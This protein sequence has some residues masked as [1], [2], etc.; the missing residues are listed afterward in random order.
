MAATP[1][2][3][4]YDG[5]AIAYHVIGDGE[6]LVVLPGGPGRPSGYLGDLGGL[7]RS[8]RLILMDLRGTGDSATPEDAG[9]YRVDRQARDVEALVN[10][11]GLGPV[12]VLGHS[13]GA[14]MAVLFA[15]AHPERVRRL[16]LVTPSG[17]VLGV[18]MI[19]FEEAVAARSAEPWYADAIA[20]DAALE[21]LPD[22]AD[23][24]ERVQL[25]ARVTPFFYGRWDAAAAAHSVAFPH[26]DAA[27][28]G[29]YR[30]FTSDAPAVRAQLAAM[31]A[32]TLVVAGEV[33]GMPTPAVAEVI[34]KVFRNGRA[35]TVAGG[36]YPW[37]D[38]SAVF[39]TTIREFLE[40]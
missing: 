27:A 29:Y 10:H 30:D 33:D 12:D 40:A 14:S 11:L 32:P 8:R 22:D 31:A 25:L 34:A 2:F 3:S 38:D 19:G 4:S 21:D 6:P 39:V 35:A 26:V 20:A 24:A 28:I 1:T 15:A 36:H 23:L 13:A 5:V 9:S 17:R 7:S 37:V 16:I 18:P